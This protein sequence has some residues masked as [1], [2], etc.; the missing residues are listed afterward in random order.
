MGGV[1]ALA[2]FRELRVNSLRVRKPM[3]V[4]ALRHHL[5]LFLVAEGARK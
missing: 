5:M 3:A 1:V 4:L 2:A